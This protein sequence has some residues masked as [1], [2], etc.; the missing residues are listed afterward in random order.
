MRNFNL[1]TEDKITGHR[2]QSM[3]TGSNGLRSVVQL[4]SPTPGSDVTT[5]SEYRTARKLET[6]LFGI[7]QYTLSR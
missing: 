7:A 5:V 6:A 1:T 2:L 4:D 3:H